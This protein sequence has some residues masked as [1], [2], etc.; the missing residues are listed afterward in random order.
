MAKDLGAEAMVVDCPLCQFN[1]DFR[2]EEVEK[3]Y[4]ARFALPVFYFTQLLGLCLGLRVETLG[5]KKL[6]VN[7]FILLER[8]NVQ[9]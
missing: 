7:P 5:L 8:K 1:L 4:G 6:N 3:K 2:Q 9:F